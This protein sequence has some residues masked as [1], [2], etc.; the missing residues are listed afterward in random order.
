VEHDVVL[1]RQAPISISGCSEPIS[2]FAAMT[3]TRIVPG[4]AIAAARRCM[5]TRPS[6]LTGTIVSRK[7]CDSSRRQVSRTALCSIAVVT[8]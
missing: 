7:P 4:S 8:M 3:L 6:G 5:S 2:L 1:A